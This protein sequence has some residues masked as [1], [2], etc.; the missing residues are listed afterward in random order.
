MFSYASQS[1]CLTPAHVAEKDKANFKAKLAADSVVLDN[2]HDQMKSLCLKLESSEGAI[3]SR[4]FFHFLTL[5][6]MNCN[7]LEII[8]YDVK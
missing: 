5:F 6:H 3:K 8:S 2:L 4:K 7:T 1:Y